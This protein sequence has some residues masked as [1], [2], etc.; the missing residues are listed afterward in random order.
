MTMTRLHTGEVSY[1][2]FARPLARRARKLPR[3]V[4]T[5]RVADAFRDL[6]RALQPTVSLEVGAHEAGFSRWIKNEV[7]DARCVAF[8][9]NPYVH[10]KY[11]DEL[12]ETG[13][14]YHHLAISDVDGTVD[15][16]IPRRL[17]NTRKGRRFRKLRTSRMASLSR[18]RY[19]VRTE[20]V[21]VPSLP[22][23]DFLHVTDDDVIV[24]WIDVEGASGPVLTAGR[25]VLSRASLVYIEVENEQVWD[26]QWL[27]VDVAAF[28]AECG[29]VPVLRDVQ[30]R[31][32]YNVVFAAADLADHPRIRAAR[33]AVYRP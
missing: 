6:C 17:H 13:V 19:A 11:D 15:L 1:Q 30:R 21:A 20:T 31:H 5:A 25:E 29:L 18:H 10:Q 23:D 16:G 24:A 27:D 32:Q 2:A 14:E 3:D 12:A 9:A 33:A 22:L 26:D 28:L 7:P 8:E 4:V